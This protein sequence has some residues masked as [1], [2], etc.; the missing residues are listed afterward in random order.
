[1]VIEQAVTKSPSTPN[2]KISFKIRKVSKF[3]LESE[4]EIGNKKMEVCGLG[5]V[6]HNLE[7]RG[8]CRQI[9]VSSRTAWSLSLCIVSTRPLGYR[10][11]P[12]HKAK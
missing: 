10:M 3:Y 4:V 9:F 11:R 5:V 2:P 7:G 12:W 8:K 1:M 6:V